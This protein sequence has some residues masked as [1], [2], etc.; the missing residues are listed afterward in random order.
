MA[1]EAVTEIDVL[2]WG[3][4]LFLGENND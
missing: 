2:P 1:T 3:N 4:Q